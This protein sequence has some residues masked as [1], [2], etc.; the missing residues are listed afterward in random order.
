[1]GRKNGLVIA[2]AAAALVLAGGVAAR[3]SSHTEKAGG[4][5]VM[6]E[7]VNEC[8]GKGACATSAGGS[9]AGTNECKGKGAVPMSAD[10]C[11]K[12]GGKV[13]EKKM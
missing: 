6:C 2:S 12:K 9:C 11:V 10:E 5:K 13:S 7:G 1:M 3:A 8:K 4:E